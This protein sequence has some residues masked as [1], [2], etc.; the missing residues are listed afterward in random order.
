MQKLTK[1]H[2]FWNR[3]HRVDGKLTPYPLPPTPPLRV[4]QGESFLIETVDTLHR[5]IMSEA[6]IGKPSGPMAGNPWTGPVYIEGICAGDVIAVS[7]ED[8]QVTDHCLLGMEKGDTL[9]PAELIEP[10]EDFIRI[11]D[12]VAYFPGGMQAPIRP[13]F[14]CFGVVPT[15]ARPEPYEHGGNM[16][17]PDICAGNI[18]HI[19]CERDGAYF[20]C[21]DG[22]ALQGDGEI[23]GFSL[24]VS[25]LGQLSIAKS[26][27]QALRTIMIETP[28]KFI[29]VG[30]K[31]EIRQGVEDAVHSMSDLLARTKNIS[32]CDAYQLAS[33]VGD[34][35]LGAM[36]PMW[37]TEWHIPIPVCLH[38]EK[39]Y[40]N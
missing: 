17:I 6:D 28:D 9:L 27:Y 13:M 39:A 11:K 25:L 12:G 37:H 32:L 24:E 36:W 33:H 1:E 23:N 40:F 21:G 16:D 19:R 31:H 29:T 7:I 3:S 18:V 30:I 15:S 2:L 26:K 8:I 35:R 14:G 20:G 10:R 38:L 34:I 22:H 4:A 5:S